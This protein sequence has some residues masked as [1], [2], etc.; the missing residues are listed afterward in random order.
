MDVPV[1]SIVPASV[2]CKTNTSLMLVESFYKRNPN[3]S[4]LIA[5]P[6]DVLKEQ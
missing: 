4:V 2:K 1:G 3:F 5:V 6:T